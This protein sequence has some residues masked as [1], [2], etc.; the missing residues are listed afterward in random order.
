MA[1][2]AL[3]SLSSEV[4]ELALGAPPS[5]RWF[6]AE[7]V[8]LAG[9]ADDGAFFACGAGLG[10]ELAGAALRLPLAAAVV[11]DGGTGS[12]ESSDDSHMLVTEGGRK[13]CGSL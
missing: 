10:F 8:C 7:G 2:F 9:K 11:A 5:L 1:S 6:F 12:S 4:S 3:L 13:V